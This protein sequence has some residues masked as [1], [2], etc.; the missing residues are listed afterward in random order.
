MIESFLGNPAQVFGQLKNCQ[1]PRQL[2][3][4]L[5]MSD[6]SDP[7]IEE[8]F[9][10]EA[11]SFKSNIQSAF[12]GPPSKKALARAKEKSTSD[13]LQAY[14]N[15]AGE[16]ITKH[17][18]S[19]FEAIVLASGLFSID[20]NGICDYLRSRGWDANPAAVANYY[21]KREPWFKRFMAK[22]A[23]PIEGWNDDISVVDFSP[24]GFSDGP[25]PKELKPIPDP[26]VDPAVPEM[27]PSPTA[28]INPESL[29]IG[30]Q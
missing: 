1:N 8:L 7:Y 14:R 5:F 12:A 27:V 22:I 25:A 21:K 20:L 19:E 13:K 2:I 10:L 16:L 28:G 6:A 15:L 17:K 24:V 26:E 30:P 9:G 29:T 18:L 3:L 11:K 4:S 23:P